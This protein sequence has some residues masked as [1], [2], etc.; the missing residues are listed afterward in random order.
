MA[1]YKPE[2]FTPVSGIESVDIPVLIMINREG[3]L[4][5]SN[6]DLGIY[7][8]DKSQYD[9]S[10]NRIEVSIYSREWLGNEIGTKE[11]NLVTKEKSYKLNLSGGKTY[12]IN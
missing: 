4:Y 10:G 2:C 7:D 8:Y 1:I 12:K 5:I 11:C 3:E 9:A 6:P